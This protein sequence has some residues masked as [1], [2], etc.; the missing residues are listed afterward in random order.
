VIIVLKIIILINL[1]IM[2]MVTVMLAMST[3]IPT[4]SPTSTIH[5][6]KGKRVGFP[7]A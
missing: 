6:R 2:E 5:A 7:T 1:I 4:V 3:T